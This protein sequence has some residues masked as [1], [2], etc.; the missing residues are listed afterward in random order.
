MTKNIYTGK[1]KCQDHGIGFDSTGNF[2][3]PDAETGKNVI[4]FG[5][6][7]SNSK[8]VN[9]KTKKVLVL[10]RGLIQ[11]IDESTIY[12]EKMYS[13]NFTIANKTFCLRQ[14]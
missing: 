7:M 4:T 1:Y 5:V 14:S 11:K 2:S 10:C 8:H 9:N 12:A 6:D 3:H 13:S